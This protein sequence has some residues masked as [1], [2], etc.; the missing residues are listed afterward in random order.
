LKGDP[1]YEPLRQKH[2]E[3]HKH[4]AEIIKQIKGGDSNIEELIGFNSV[5]GKL[6]SEIVTMIMRIKKA[7]EKNSAA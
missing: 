2:A 6:S 3:F 1:N 5:F 7:T 4:T